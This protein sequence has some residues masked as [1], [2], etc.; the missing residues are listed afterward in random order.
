MKE[1]LISEFVVKKQISG[2]VVKSGVKA[3][4]PIRVIPTDA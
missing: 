3:G 4:P 2:L 1:K